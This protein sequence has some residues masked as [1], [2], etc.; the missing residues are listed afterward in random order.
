MD[1][2]KR[3]LSNQGIG[4]IPLLVFLLVDNYLSY[5]LSFV[6]SIFL[7]LICTFIYRIFSRGKIYQFSLIPS[8]IVLLVYALF[9]VVNTELVIYEH[10]SLFIELILELTLVLVYFSRGYVI[11]K[12]KRQKKYSVALRT[13]IRNSLSEFYYICRIYLF[14]YLLHLPFVIFFL[15]SAKGSYDSPLMKVMLDYMPVI[16]GILIL[17]YEH[18]RIRLV[19]NN[20]KK[21]TWLPVVNP[22]GTVVG[23][24]A[25]SV[26]EQ[27]AKKYMHPVV[28]IVVMYKGML[29]LNKRKA[30]EYVSPGLLDYPFH[31]YVLF[32]ETIEHC[33]ERI[34]SPLQ[35]KNS[36]PRHLLTYSFENEKTKQL[37]SLFLLKLE[38]EAQ[39]E[40][41][42]SG[43][44]WTARQIEQNL[45]SSYLFSEYFVKEFPYL[46]S[47]VLMVEQL[48]NHPDKGSAES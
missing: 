3:G 6:I 7:S 9:M 23:S 5:T 13:T 43:K 2:V 31:S 26:S 20:L 38:Q 42:H 19:S 32:Q 14:A 34:L 18:I 35:N 47:T 8:A 4:F 12:A 1:K 40:D 37:V 16:I 48:M 22:K 27:S 17:L 11:A 45:N 21:E 36:S 46:Q 28:R 15:I 44:L 33:L 39:L 10:S 30:N 25:R 29:Y 41:F 24:I